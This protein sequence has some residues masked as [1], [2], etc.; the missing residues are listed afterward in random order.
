M[1]ANNSKPYLDYLNE[2]VDK[3]NNTYLFFYW[4]KTY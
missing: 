3:Y 1:A 4:E 2:V